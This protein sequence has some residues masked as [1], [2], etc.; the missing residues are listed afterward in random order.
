[1]TPFSYFLRG[2]EREELNWIDKM[3]TE[4][5]TLQINSKVLTGRRYCM[6][7]KVLVHSRNCNVDRRYTE[8]QTLVHTSTTWCRAMMDA[9]THVKRPRAGC[10]DSS[11]NYNRRTAEKHGSPAT[12]SLELSAASLMDRQHTVDLR[13]F[14]RN[15]WLWFYVGGSCH[16][17]QNY[18]LKRQKDAQSRRVGCWFSVG[19]AAP[20]DCSHDMEPFDL[21]FI[22]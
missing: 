17:A 4:N 14:A 18:K 22:Q 21:I 8:I 3:S 10:V 5:Q 9:A 1:M 7:C 11:I 12:C 19:L 20:A 6:S 2:W 16:S 15:S 13:L